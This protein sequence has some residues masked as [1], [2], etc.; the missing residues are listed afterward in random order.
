[1][2]FSESLRL[3]LAAKA[4]NALLPSKLGELSKAYFLKVD[5][6]VVASKALSAVVLEKA[7]DL[8]G[9]CTVLLA[10]V[11]LAPDW[12]RTIGLGAIIAL[13]VLVVLC[14]VLVLPLKVLFGKLKDIHPWLTR[15]A[16]FLEGWDEVIGGWKG[17]GGMLPG[18][19][20]LSIFLWCLHV[21]QIYLFF[22][23]LNEVVP[24]A[25]ALAFI[26]LAIL[27]G[28]LPVTIGGMGTRD[29]ALIF[30]FAAYAGAP[31]V[32]G[33]GLLC[34]MRYWVDSLL[35][36]PFFHRYASRVGEDK[37]GKDYS[38]QR[39]EGRRDGVSF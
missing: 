7:L 20:L 19:L 1:M 30:L 31:V 35:G 18:I 5:A 22:P 2:K 14:L 10:G 9:L 28:L 4:L 25:P 36:V 11:V 39:R 24:V 27:I 38:P 13:G 12:T 37:G 32:A 26:P 33:V 6:Q 8:G 16:R 17:R 3:V 15:F 34:S 23:S 29:S 21:L